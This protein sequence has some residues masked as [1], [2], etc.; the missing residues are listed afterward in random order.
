MQRGKL[1]QARKDKNLTQ[2]QLADILG[3]TLNYYYTV[4]SGKVPGSTA[5]WDKLEEILGTPKQELKQITEVGKV[6]K[7]LFKRVKGKEKLR[8]VIKDTTVWFVYKDLAELLKLTV[9]QRKEFKRLPM[10]D[11]IRV[12]K[13]DN[14]T[15][16]LINISGLFYLINLHDDITQARIIK[17]W[18]INKVLPK[19]WGGSKNDNTYV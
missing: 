17:T 10:Y 3:V 19:I 2:K 14:K 18:V 6:D 4:E 16:T 15:L 9:K 1:K 13:R 5:L 8:V 11:D 12:I 7:K